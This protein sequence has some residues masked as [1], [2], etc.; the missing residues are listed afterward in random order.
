MLSQ[1]AAKTHCPVVYCNLVGGNDE[2]IFDG[3]SMVFD[4]G[5]ADGRR[6]TF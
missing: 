6:Q 3:G 2:L 5:P 1:L 4:A